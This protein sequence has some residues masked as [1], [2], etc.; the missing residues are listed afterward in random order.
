MENLTSKDFKI[1]LKH[2]KLKVPKN[3]TKRKKK[4]IKT[5]AGKLCRCIK[6]VKKKRSNRTM[7]NYKRKDAA[8]IC[9][10]SIFKKRG[11]KH[12]RFNCKKTPTLLQSKKNRK[13][14]RKTI[15]KKFNMKY[16]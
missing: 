1:I 11:L 15:K 5:L 16:F 14:L 9:S 4:A 12:Y 6:K 13:Y 10:S 7:K 3:K 2:Y 8:A